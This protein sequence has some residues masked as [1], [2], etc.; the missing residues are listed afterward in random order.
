MSKTIYSQEQK[1]GELLAFPYVRNE[2]AIR[3]IR[4]HE[5]AKATGSTV[6]S[7]KEIKKNWM[8]L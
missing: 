5:L 4:K 8:F 2:Q 1:N 6:L 7:C 3:K